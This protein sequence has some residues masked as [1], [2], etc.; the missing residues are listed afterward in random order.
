MSKSR[1]DI[2]CE[3]N[4]KGTNSGINR[5]KEREDDGKKPD[6]NNNRETSQCTKANALSVMHSNHLLPN[7]IKRCASEPKSD[8][9]VNKHQYHSRVPE[10]ILG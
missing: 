2:D 9:L 3:T 1:D 6:R 7:K 10:P 5:T 8:E 4:K